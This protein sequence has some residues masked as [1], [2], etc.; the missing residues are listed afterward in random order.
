MTFDRYRQEGGVVVGNY[1]SETDAERV[2]RNLQEA[3][4][5]SE[6]ISIVAQ[7]KDRAQDVAQDTGTDVAEGAGI[8]AATG[9]VLGVLGGLLVGAT[10]LTI[11]GIGIVVGGPLAAVLV[12]GATGAVTGGLAGALA[13]LG[14]SED[15]AKQYQQRMEAGDILVVVAA[16]ER[17]AEARRIMQG[18]TDRMEYRGEYR[19]EDSAYRREER[20]GEPTDITFTGGS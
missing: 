12:G 9:G 17:E 11:P 1:S 20:V 18:D 16:G 19:R 2:V 15:D 6:S 3:G 13:G 8:G 10:A 14:V 4:F 5:G 7:D